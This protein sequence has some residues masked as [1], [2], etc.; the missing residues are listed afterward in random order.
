MIRDLAWFVIGQALISWPC[1]EYG[2][3]KQPKNHGEARSHASRGRTDFFNDPSIVA[4][5]EKHSWTEQRF[6]ALGQ[7]IQGA[8]CM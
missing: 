7:T 8:S 6:H 1:A 2:T 3:R 4:E 5:D